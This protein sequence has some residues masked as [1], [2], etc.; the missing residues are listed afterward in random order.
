MVS[1][2]GTM[3]RRGSFVKFIS[4]VVWSG[5]Q[6][7]IQ[8]STKTIATPWSMVVKANW[9]IMLKPDNGSAN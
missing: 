8:L 1:N 2:F 3:I 5:G 7:M 6:I 4:E 9:D